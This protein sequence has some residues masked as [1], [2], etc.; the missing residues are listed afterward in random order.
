MSASTDTKEPWSIYDQHIAEHLASKPFCCSVKAGDRVGF[1]SLQACPDVRTGY[2]NE[3][4]ESFARLI[5]AAPDLLEALKEIDSDFWL[6][7]KNGECGKANRMRERLQ[8]AIAQ[9]QPGEE[10]EGA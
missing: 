7:P 1:A 4:I 6:E 2:S 8:A 9:A 5:A 10:V 3:E